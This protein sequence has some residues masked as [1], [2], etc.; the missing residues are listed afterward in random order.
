VAS[1]IRVLVVDDSLITIQAITRVLEADPTVRVVGRALG[2]EQALREVERL[3]PDVITMDL[4]MPGM[5]GIEATKQ[6]VQSFGTPIVIVSAYATARGVA[7]QTLQALQHGAIESV[8]K[9]SGEIGLHMDV[10]GAELLAKVRAASKAHPGLQRRGRSTELSATAT[11]QTRA[12]SWRAVAPSRIRVVG[13]GISTG[14]AS[15]LDRII[16]QLPSDFAVP[17]VVVIHMSRQFVPILAERLDAASRVRVSLAR[18]GEALQPGCVYFAPADVHLEVRP[19]LR[20][21]LVAGRAV[22]GCIPSA[23]VLFASLARSVG[24]EALGLLL[25]GMGRD[26]VRGLAAIKARGGVTAAQDQDSSVI[27]GMP[28]AALE[29]GAAAYEVPLAHVVTFLGRAVWS[30]GA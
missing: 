7:I 29:S 8:Q 19:E 17:I 28:R 24:S 25:T 1:V 23:D 20:V 30:H 21:Q 3:N 9:P 26:G 27:F 6:I 10:V 5:D 2:G 22:S 14:G 11:L 18:D 12:A 15:T 13:I 4:Q 16:P